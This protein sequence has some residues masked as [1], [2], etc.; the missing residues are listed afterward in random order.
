MND[1]ECILIWDAHTRMGHNIGRYAYGTSHTRIWANIRI[2][3]RTQAH[4]AIRGVVKYVGI[5]LLLQYLFIILPCIFISRYAIYV[6]HDYHEILYHDFYDYHGITI[7]QQSPSLPK[8]TL[9]G[10][11]ETYLAIWPLKFL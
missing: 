10:G 8:A 5:H 4:M 6:Y 1:H 9:S 7:I 3:D 11:V 2:W